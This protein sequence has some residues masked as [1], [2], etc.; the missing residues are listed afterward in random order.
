[1]YKYE[2]N[3]VITIQAIQKLVYVRRISTMQ[4]Q[5]CINKGFQVTNILGEERK[6]ILEDFVVLHGFRDVFIK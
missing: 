6:P 5:K 4:F 2:N 3:A 1:V